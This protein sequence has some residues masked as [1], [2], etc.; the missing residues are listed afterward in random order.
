M[1]RLW[2]TGYR[3]FELNTFGDKDP[4]IKII[5]LALK[6]RLITLI[7]NSRL[8]WLI[9]GAN[10]GV[11]QW[12]CEVALELREEYPLQ[13][14]IIVPYEKFSSRWNKAHQQKFI[15]LQNKVDF[16]ASTSNRPYQS[17]V[18]LRN[19]QNFMLMHTDESLMIY[20][21]DY[22]GKPKF[23]YELIKQYQENKDYSL[24]LI[25]FYD[26]QEVAEEYQSKQ[27]DN[28]FKK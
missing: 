11:D 19:Y 25:N 14:S 28:Y 22:P 21:P 13:I 20:D 15:E 8:D 3:N 5:K 12:A 24:E 6:D 23:D 17:P 26:L 2:V 7:K 1:Q 4:K 10:L 27:E 16:F 18:Q 9:T